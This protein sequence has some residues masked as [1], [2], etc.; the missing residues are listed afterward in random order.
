MCLLYIS[1]FFVVLTSLTHPRKILL[2][3]L[4]IGNRKSQRFI[5]TP[6]YVRNSRNKSNKLYSCAGCS[7]RYQLSI[8]CWRAA[9]PVRKFPSPEIN[10]LLSLID[11]F[12][13]RRLNFK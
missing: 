12:H 6:T 10:L 2:V 9:V 7:E 3:V 5:N 8:S 11:L 1:P 13:T 4:Q